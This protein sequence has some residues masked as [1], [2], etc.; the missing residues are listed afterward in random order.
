MSSNA[1]DKLVK[2]ARGYLALW[3]HDDRYRKELAEVVSLARNP[4]PGFH[5]IM[6]MLTQLEGLSAYRSALAG[7]KFLTGDDSA[8]QDFLDGFVLHHW[9]TFASSALV[10]QSKI[11]GELKRFN[12][13]FEADVA[14]GFASALWLNREPYLDAYRQWL[15]LIQQ[16]KLLGQFDD[17]EE[18]IHFAYH[19]AA[20]RFGTQVP[21][22][23][24]LRDPH[25]AAFQLLAQGK[26]HE[27]YQHLLDDHLKRAA[28]CLRY[29]KSPYFPGVGYALVPVEVLAL[30]ELEGSYDEMIA[31]LEHPLLSPL[32][33]NRD[34]L[35][36][37]QL[38]PEVQIIEDACLRFVASQGGITGR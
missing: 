37:V 32:Y 25:D 31:T 11:I 16:H 10:G 29:E 12:S 26:R 14:C 1:T 27:A 8:W 23:F 7:T 38:T 3:E 28:S 9:S 22:Q 30:W 5:D 18:Q 33:K 6:M 19:L 13:G 21:S 17:D 24:P 2:K 15:P 35:R 20:R 36:K 4:P 34:A